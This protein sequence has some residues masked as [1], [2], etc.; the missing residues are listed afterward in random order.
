MDTISVNDR[1]FFIKKML[2]HGKGGYSYL[3]EDENKNVFV[4]KKIHHEPCDYYNFGNKIESEKNDYNRLVTTG[5][6]LPKMYSIDE[7]RETILKEYIKGDTAFNLVKN[8]ALP[9]DAINKIENI[10]QKVT[11]FG[12]KIDYFPTNFVMQDGKFYYIDYECNNYM[13]EW[14]FN[15]WGIKY[16][17]KTKEFNEYLRVH[18]D[19]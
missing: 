5:I 18:K 10:A 3:V 19:L 12:L 16:W 14:N 1:V 6:P 2:G 15:N 9:E 13:D 11:E 7:G 8:D 17:S 4:V